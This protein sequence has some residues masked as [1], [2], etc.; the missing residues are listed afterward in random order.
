MLT[1]TE[2]QYASMEYII[3]SSNTK[4]INDESSLIIL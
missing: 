2:R 3:G 4:V 1:I